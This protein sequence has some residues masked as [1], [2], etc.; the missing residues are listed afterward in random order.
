MKVN[1]FIKLNILNKILKMVDNDDQRIFYRSN[2]ALISFIPEAKLISANEENKKLLEENDKKHIMT[3]ECYKSELNILRGENS[4]ILR[5]NELL[6]NELVALK[7]DFNTQKIKMDT[8]RIMFHLQDLNDIYELEAN[9]KDDKRFSECMKRVRDMTVDNAHYM[10][11]NDSKLM[12]RYKT[13]LIINEIKTMDISIK[14]QIQ[15]FTSYKF[16]D[17]IVSFE[18]KSLVKQEMWLIDLKDRE[19]ADYMLHE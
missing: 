17:S 15:K 1:I 4:D 14:E 2:S 5:Q 8:K 9:V 12:Q 13:G 16:I 11:Y 3:V 7:C 10:S 18:Y 19:F 6:K